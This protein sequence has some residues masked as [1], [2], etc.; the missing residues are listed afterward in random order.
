MGKMLYGDIRHGMN[1]VLQVIFM[2]L[3]TGLFDND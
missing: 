1:Q 2:V 3:V